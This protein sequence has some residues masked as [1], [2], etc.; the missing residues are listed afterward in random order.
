M[1]FNEVEAASIGTISLWMRFVVAIAAGFIA[2]KISVT[3]MTI[4]SFIFMIFGGLVFSADIIK[5]GL[6][7]LF[8]VNIIA[9]SIG[10]YALRGLYF[11][12]MEEGKVP[13]IYT[14]TAVGIISV[15]GYTPDIFMGPLMGY[16]LDNSP[17]TVG[18]QHVFMVLTIFSVIGFAASI[19]YRKFALKK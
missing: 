19:W 16:L 3:K 9:I 5:P 14:G 12:I 15:I 7:W 4:F 1:L 8:F 2:D 17:G 10:I 13:L 11:A 18:H 6:F